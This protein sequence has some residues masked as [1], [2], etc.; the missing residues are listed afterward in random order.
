MNLKSGQTTTVLNNY[1]IVSMPFAHEQVIKIRCIKSFEELEYF[2]MYIFLCV[3]CSDSNTTQRHLN[4]R[5]KQ[6]LST[7]IV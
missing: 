4:L 6:T 2:P 5:K 7:E 3:F 1:E